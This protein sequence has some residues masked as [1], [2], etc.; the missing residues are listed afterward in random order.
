MLRGLGLAPIEVSHSP[1]EVSQTPQQLLEVSQ[2]PQQQR[3]PL[4]LSSR[5]FLFYI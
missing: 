3:R 1:I 4:L 5:A 2:T